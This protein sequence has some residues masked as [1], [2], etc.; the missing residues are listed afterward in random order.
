MGARTGP[1]K[2]R[3]VG[4][5]CLYDFLC[6]RLNFSFLMITLLEYFLHF[7]SKALADKCLVSDLFQNI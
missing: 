1:R 7:A 3:V 5:V 4:K 2:K 6:F